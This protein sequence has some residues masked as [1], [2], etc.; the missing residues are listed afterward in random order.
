MKKIVLK[1]DDIFMVTDERGDLP[2]SQVETGV[3]WHGT[4]FLRICDLFLEGQALTPLSHSVSA[5]SDACQINL[6]NA[7]VSFDDA[8]KLPEDSIHVRRQWQ[9]KKHQVTQVITLTSYH[10]DP[11]ICKLSLKFGSDFRDIFEIRGTVRSARG[12]VFSPEIARPAVMLSYGG[13]DGILRKTQL[14][15]MPPATHTLDGE[16]FW[17]LALQKESGRADNGHD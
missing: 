6:T 5:T 16:V 4:R 2:V 17:L 1:Y 7:M 8:S 13:R 9:I 10:A 12:H 11:V 3:F 14:T 15:L